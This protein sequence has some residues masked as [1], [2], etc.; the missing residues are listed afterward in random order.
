MVAGNL[1]DGPASLASVLI[2]LVQSFS[3]NTLGTMS[4]WLDTI[5]NEVDELAVS[6]HTSQVCF[7]LMHW[8]A[9]DNIYFSFGSIC[10]ICC[11]LNCRV[12]VIIVDCHITS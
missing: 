5:S 11:L 7:V 8:N 9:I 12:I 10:R 2:T 1:N 6:K 3:M 4:M